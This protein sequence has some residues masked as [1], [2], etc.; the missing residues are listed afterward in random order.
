MARYRQWDVNVGLVLGRE[1]AVVIDTRSSGIQGAEIQDDIRALGAG[2]RV[3]HV[4]NTHVHFD[5]TLGNCA[6]EGAAVYAHE[7]VGRTIERDSAAV[8][9]LFRADPRDAPEYGYTAADVVGVLATEVRVPD[10]TF[11]SVVKVDLGNRRV[12]MTHTGRGHTDGDVVVTVPDADVAFF[13][14]LVEESAH[15]SLGEDCWP[16][17]WAPTLDAHAVGLGRGSVV[18]PGHGLPV[19][20]SFVLRQREDLAVVAAVIAERRAAGL[21]LEQASRQPDDR[22]PYPLEW[23]TTAFARAWGQ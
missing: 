2:I 23:L 3:R 21:T 1:G 11:D 8:M 7:N 19:G 15:P 6:F 20:S 5:H 12:V 16:L 13:G 10:V 18:V 9:E 4:V 17:E 22:L 14:D